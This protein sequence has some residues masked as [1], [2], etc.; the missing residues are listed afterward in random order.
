[1]RTN[2]LVTIETSF[3]TALNE[4][5][6]GI[7]GFVPT[8]LGAL[9]VFFIGLLLANWLKTFTIKLINVTKVGNLITNPAIKDFLKNAETSQKIEEVIGEIVRWVV[10][11]L[12]FMAS[13]NILGLTTVSAFLNTV[14]GYLPNLFA[15]VFILLIGVVLAGILEKVVKGSLGG[16]DV[17]LSRF[18]G[19]FVSYTVMIISALAALSQMG[20][21][22]SF[23]EVIFTGFVATLAIAFGLGVGLGSKDI[24]KEILDE[25][26][27]NFKKR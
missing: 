12:F 8:L 25:A 23:I 24:I 14:F 27:K 11:I 3:A 10:L 26:Y 6:L 13:M 1:M 15:A 19:K 9:L 22:Q 21:A 17:S 2:A 5:M 4:I 7:V 18:M 16:V 20:I